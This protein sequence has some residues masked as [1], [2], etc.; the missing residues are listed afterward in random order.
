MNNRRMRKVGAT[1]S[2][3]AL[4][5]IGFH[6]I[7]KAIEADVDGAYQN[8][9]S[10]ALVS[11]KTP[12]DSS[13]KKAESP[14]CESIQ[15]LVDKGIEVELVGEAEGE[16]GLYQMWF[17]DL[18]TGDYATDVTILWGEACGLAY[19]QYDDA[20]TNRV[21]LDVA[22][23]LTL[24]FYRKIAADQGGVE[25]YE[26]NLRASFSEEGHEHD[27]RYRDQEPT[28]VTKPEITSVQAWAWNELGVNLPTGSFTI[29]NI[30]DEWQYD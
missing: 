2:I 23:S 30:D 7:T 16:N 27:F 17:Y 24:Q 4:L 6:G 12:S 1:I 20:I 21:P 8:N 28:E 3:V 9:W 10:A 29:K 13:L 11:N 25:Q 26:A 15:S 5:V 18:P 22:R 19:T 14:A